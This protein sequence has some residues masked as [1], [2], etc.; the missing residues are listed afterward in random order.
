MP[1][2]DIVTMKD[3]ENPGKTGEETED[4]SVVVTAD[5]SSTS[6]SLDEAATSSSTNGKA[7]GK[8]KKFGWMGGV[9]ALLV[10]T[11][12]IVSVAVSSSK[13]KGSSTSSL[14]GFWKDGEDSASGNHKDKPGCNKTHY[15]H[16]HHAHGGNHNHYHGHHGRDPLDPNQEEEE[17]PFSVAAVQ[18]SSPADSE[19]EE[20]ELPTELPFGDVPIQ[21]FS[22]DILQGYSTEEEL[23][24]DLTKTGKHILNQVILQN[25]AR[26]QYYAQTVW[27]SAANGGDTPPRERPSTTSSAAQQAGQEIA[28]AASVLTTTEASKTN[29]QEEDVDEADII[30]NDQ[31]Y[32]YAVLGDFLVVWDI[33]TGAQVTQV[34]MPSLYGEDHIG[35]NWN[36]NPVTR[37]NGLLLTPDHVILMVDAHNHQNDEQQQEPG[38]PELIS[39]YQATQLRVYSKPTPTKTEMTL[40]ATQ[41]LQGIYRD[42]RWLEDSQTIHLVMSGDINAY[43]YLVEPLSYRHFRDEDENSPLSPMEYV[44]AATE[45]ATNTLL[46]EFVTAV[47]N[48]L[49]INGQLPEMLQ[50]NG[51]AASTVMSPSAEE[52]LARLGGVGLG[53][54][55]NDE[56]SNDLPL[57]A[58]IQVVSLHV[59]DLPPANAMSII[60]QDALP[61]T[62]S[63]LMGP[64]TRCDFYATG[65]HL[66]VAL[67]HVQYNETT[68][69]VNENVF[70]VHLGVEEAS[71]REI[72]STARVHANFHSVVS[73]PGHLNNGAYSLDIQGND[74]RLATTV[75][76]WSA[77]ERV[78]QVCG[79]RLEMLN[80]NGASNNN[81]DECQ[82][83]DSWKQCF[84]LAIDGCTQIE[85]TGCPYTY[86]CAQSHQESSTDNYIMVFDLA[87]NDMMMERGRIRIGED[88]EI[89]TSVRF[90]ETFSYATTFDQRDPFYVLR[91]EPE[92]PP[93][94]L[95]ELK[96]DGFSRY[97][98]PLEDFE[99]NKLLVGIG[100]NSTGTGFDQRNTG[101]MITVFDVTDPAAP[102]AVASHMLENDDKI[103][104]YTHAAWDAKAV[105]Y[106]NGKLVLPV[107]M[108]HN[109]EWDAADEDD[110]L[111]GGD[112]NMDDFVDEEDQ[113]LAVERTHEDDKSMGGNFNGFFVFNV[114]P[115][116]IS[117]A[118]RI[119]NAMVAGACHYC[120]GGLTDSRSIVMDDGS[121]MTMFDDSVQSTNMTTGET[122]WSMSVE[123]EGVS[124]DC[125]W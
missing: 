54:F 119:D 72:L 73:V 18:E 120:D 93:A 82:T 34:Q 79:E 29:N 92:Q 103:E 13:D 77:L 25:V 105:Q 78:G 61:V 23:Q 33:H 59:D 107:T 30:K 67:E 96:L 4:P 76:K 36:W 98:H 48:A 9:L 35:R 43:S 95:G 97:L 64:T 100:Q 63:L 49:K 2:E 114:G 69:A 106:A 19:E 7:V 51:W 89:I 3:L 22:S 14:S 101:V 108:Y 38:Q 122:L 60:A 32:V 55:H 83:H 56:A 53:V 80:S 15:N 99:D 28:S 125:C 86:T 39:K 121:L 81:E 94:I 115:G 102:V 11:V 65:N 62:S 84:D 112:V 42:G 24:D 45:L 70:V 74:L 57:R 110:S 91:L 116:G 90:G 1:E 20:V 104:S 8:K 87:S 75:Q 50:I 124:K 68:R 12:V 26:H 31:N 113:D 85:T 27:G 5:D 88:H 16:G 17:N 117:E 44:A 41:K 109:G 10:L 111:Q 47:T 21:G 66:V 123:L 46:P 40:L 58:F 71:E 52:T 37:I 118:L 6:G